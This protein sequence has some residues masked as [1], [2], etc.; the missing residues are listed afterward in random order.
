MSRQ[1]GASPIAPAR[2]PWLVA[3]TLAGDWRHWLVMGSVVLVLVAAAAVMVLLGA[4]GLTHLRAQPVRSVDISGEFRYLQREAVTATLDQLTRDA[5]MS[6]DLGAVR[7][8]LQAN[9]WVDRVA[10]RRHWPD[11]LEITVVEQ[12]PIAYWG[13]SAL[14]N[15][16]GELFRPDSIPVIAGLPV[17]KGPGESA[18]EV[19]RRYQE[20]GKLFDAEGLTVVRLEMDERHAWRLWL[21]P[22]VEVVIGQGDMRQKLERFLA[23]YRTELKSYLGVVERIDLRYGNGLAVRW[24]AGQSPWP[25]A[26]R[27]QKSGAS[28]APTIAGETA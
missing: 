2:R 25:K 12:V 28:R 11:R 6:I 9:P 21:Q 3:G 14:L 20:L 16:R 1:R 5:L 15:Y 23:V 22:S 10:V 4:K 13:D 26:A 18:G 19:M 24:Q 27:T 8:G 17:L 7:A